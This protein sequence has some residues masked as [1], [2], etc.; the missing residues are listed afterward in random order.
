MNISTRK[1]TRVYI[2]DNI[3]DITDDQL[4]ELYK[5]F[6]DILQDNNIDEKNINRQYMVSYIEQKLK[7]IDDANLSIIKNIILKFL[8]SENEHDKKVKI[9]LELA[10]K[11]LESIKEERINDLE[12]FTDIK[13]D[14]FTND[15][16]KKVIDEMKDHIFDNGFKKY[17]CMLYQKS[18]KYPY[19]S[20]FKGVLKQV[21]YELKPQH[22]R[23]VKGGSVDAFTTY[24]VQKK[25]D[26]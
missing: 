5:R 6:L 10:N 11:I 8:A 19:L 1:S 14:V 25:E 12:E 26:V 21:G 17:D 20:I 4:K 2:I 9:A 22:K 13:R 7:Y 23:K 15:T 18:I 3:V 16:V 24:S